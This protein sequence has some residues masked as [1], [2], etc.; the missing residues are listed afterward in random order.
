M[1]ELGQEG[2]K[3]RSGNTDLGI[4]LEVFIQTMSESTIE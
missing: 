1:C 3:I 2:Y 4:L